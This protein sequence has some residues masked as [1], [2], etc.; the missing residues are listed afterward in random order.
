M[1]TTVEDMTRSMVNNLHLTWLHR[2]IE[3][4]VHKSS[5]EIREDLGIA[6]F[7][8]TSTEPIDLY[9]TVKRHILSE[10]Y[11]DED[12]LR[13]LLGVHGWAG[14]HIDVDGLGTGESIISAA[15]NGAIATLWLMAMPK[16]IVSPSTTPEELSTG[17][18]A[19]VVEMLVDSE[20]S[21]A[22][23]R[24]IMATHL[25][26]KGIGLEVFDMQALFEGQSISESFREVRTRLV[27]ALILMQATGFPVDLDDVFALSRDQL[28][29]ETS[30]YI[31]TMHARSAIRRA[32]IGGTHN[33]FEWP[34]VGN[35][36]ACASLFSTL[37]VFR[38]SASQMTSCPQFRSSSDGT[39]SPWSDRDFTS[40][41]IR[42][43]INHYASTLKA[44]KGRVNRELE[45]FIDYLKTEM[46]DIVS[47]ISES[48]DPG[49]TLFEELKFYRRAA[50]TGKMPE[51]SP[52]KRLRLIL[53]DI[54]QKT[55]GMRDNPPTL[56]ELVDYIVDAFRSITDLVNS[57]R[58]AL[59]D[60][61]H[62]FAEALC[63]ETGQ[64]LLDVFN[65]GDALMDL[66]WVSRFIAEESARAM[67]EDPMDNERSDLIERI[68]STY[69]GGVVYILVQSRSGAMVS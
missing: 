27:V 2:V 38:A 13:F 23:L 17:A 7:S 26:A 47:D 24:E 54:R 36:R 39:T 8:E 57:N 20:E 1:T 3:K 18:L 37:A 61:A 29:E 34:S 25:E 41:L 11:H 55:Q 15:R 48:S 42:E 46:T 64:R 22:Q 43:L 66:P 40:Y 63:L 35:S 65:L 4:W 30:A 59:G 28:I 6:S 52:E 9:N 68:T 32:I 56:T 60:D 5:L 31:I 45:V 16:I 44:K 50:R 69:A 19:K 12:T 14:F 53:A 62:R 58:D 49:E 51:V 67:E 33:D 10:A 21:R